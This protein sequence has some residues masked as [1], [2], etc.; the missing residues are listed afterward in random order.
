MENKQKPARLLIEVIGRYDWLF[1]KLVDFGESEIGTSHFIIV[2]SKELKRKYQALIKQEGSVVITTEEVAEMHR[3]VRFNDAY[4]ITATARQNEQ[5][6]NYR[7]LQDIMQQDRSVWSEKVPFSPNMVPRDKMLPDL[8]VFDRINRSFSVVKTIFDDFQP[9]MLLLRPGWT[10]ST[11]ALGVAA[12]KGIPCSMP[13][14]A[15]YRS[16][17]TWTLGPYS[18]HAQLEMLFNSKEI[19]LDIEENFSLQAPEGSRQVFSNFQKAYQTKAL[20]RRFLIET[21]NHSHKFVK[22]LLNKRF[23]DRPRYFTFLNRF[24]LEIQTIKYLRKIWVENADVIPG[25]KLLFLL[26]K[27]PEYTVQSLARGFCNVHAIITQIA[28]ALPAGQTLLVKEHSRL[29][30]RKLEFYKELNKFQ[31]VV[32]VNPLLPSSHYLPACDATATVAG[33]IALESC[34]LGLRCLTFSPRIE[35]KFLPNIRFTNDLYDVATA[36]DFVLDDIEPKERLVY[37]AAAARYY[38]L[39]KETS[40]DAPGTKVF[41]GNGSISADALKKSW[42][43]LCENYKFQMK[44]QDANVE[45]NY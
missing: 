45:V 22:T 38:A 16:L 26:P 12:K 5:E 37:L 17:V 29:G 6:Y 43:L 30:Y 28:V 18:H 34:Q 14:P 2:S 7:Y 1:E 13:R 40:F 10:F 24:I 15:R 27:E 4:D 19:N 21:Y 32:F 9:D 8:E 36:L 20:F 25:K 23:K 44:D 11:V 33:T 31:N 35:Y 39:L 41:E 42:F 3:L